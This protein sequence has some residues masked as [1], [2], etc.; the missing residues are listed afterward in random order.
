[1]RTRRLLALGG[2]T[3]AM[4]GAIVG[5]GIA[6][7]W[8]LLLAGLWGGSAL[9]LGVV[10]LWLAAEAHPLPIAAALV[11]IAPP[12]SILGARLGVSELGGVTA[13][14]ALPLLAALA[15]NVARRKV[16]HLNVLTAAVVAYGGFLLLGTL[17][18]PPAAAI[19]SLSGALAPLACYFIGMLLTAESGAHVDTN[20][21]HSQQRAPILRTLGWAAATGTL[22]TALV[23]VVP[24]PLPAAPIAT[25]TSAPLAGLLGVLLVFGL[26]WDTAHTFRRTLLGAAPRFARVALLAAAALTL[27]LALAAI[28]RTSSQLLLVAL[29]G[30]LLPIFALRR[31]LTE[32]ALL[33]LL[34]LL[35][36][37]VLPHPPDSS[38]STLTLLLD[39]RIWGDALAGA[40]AGPLG[41]GIGWTVPLPADTQFPLAL[42]EL[43]IPGFASLLWLLAI[44]LSTC[45]R[46]W[47]RLRPT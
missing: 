13:L 30:T 46:G 4:A 19:P 39:G 6:A 44:A 41:Q 20:G 47:W 29:A 42:R 25:S 16:A 1:M 12:A 37:L 24:L 26:S 14:L 3:G 18:G 9:G 34:A 5:S 43:G 8:A 28:A 27:S 7:G 33:G 45:W 21:T 40:G 35:L 11:A 10:A 17:D 15:G 31:R 38:Y 23:A 32:L 36:L 2:A 22:A